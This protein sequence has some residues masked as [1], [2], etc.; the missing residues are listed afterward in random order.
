MNG[1][2]KPFNMIELALYEFTLQWDEFDEIVLQQ[3]PLPSEPEVMVL[4]SNG[5][6]PQRAHLFAF[7]QLCEEMETEQDSDANPCIDFED[8]PIP[9]ELDSTEVTVPADASKEYSPDSRASPLRMRAGDGGNHNV[10]NQDSQVRES[11]LAASARREL[12]SC[13]TIEDGSI[14]EKRKER[15]VPTKKPLRRDK[16]EK[17]TKN[18]LERDAH[19]A[20]EA[21]AASLVE[22]VADE[23]AATRM[24]VLEN[25]KNKMFD[26]GSY[27]IKPVHETRAEAKLRSIL[28][29]LFIDDDQVEVITSRLDLLKLLKMNFVR[30]LWHTRK[31][32]KNFG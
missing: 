26:P 18:A 9:K 29:F 21:E 19:L 3:I 22:L 30:A 17:E 24:R 5:F 11:E 25:I 16:R 4:I 7:V 8:D 10:A 12:V 28:Y 14:L 20:R 6:D 2:T 27:P 31:D 13:L 15:E 1:R 23:I 32:N